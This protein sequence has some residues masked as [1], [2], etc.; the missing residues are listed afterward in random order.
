MFMDTNISFFSLCKK[1]IFLTKEHFLSTFLIR[2]LSS[3]LSVVTLVALAVLMIPNLFKQWFVIFIILYVVRFIVSLA[4]SSYFMH[5]YLHQPTSLRNVLMR[6]TLSFTRVSWKTALMQIILLIPISLIS[7]IVGGTLGVT[8]IIIILS[9]TAGGLEQIGSG[10][11][12]AIMGIYLGPLLA[13]FVILCTQILWAFSSFTFMA[14]YPQTNHPLRTSIQLTKTYWK[15]ILLFFFTNFLLQT[16]LFNVSLQLSLNTIVYLILFFLLFTISSIVYEFF[17][18]IIFC[19]S[20]K[21][22][23]FF[24]PAQ[25]HYDQSIAS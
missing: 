16:I 6:T 18:T 14:P 17:M 13:I 25:E 20:P 3:A 22:K 21:T 5:L 8:L 4:N 24:E 19:T 11:L 10:A 23:H 2:T 12:G 1:A 9:I 7:I 15:Q